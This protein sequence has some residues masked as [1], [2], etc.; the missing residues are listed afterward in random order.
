MDP[1][2]L[3]SFVVTDSPRVVAVVTLLCGDEGLAEDSVQEALARAFE[4][5]RRLVRSARRRARPQ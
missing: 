5:E 3:R 4:Q 2:R 1:D